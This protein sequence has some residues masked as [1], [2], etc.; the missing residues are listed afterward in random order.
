MTGL[1]GHL[2]FLGAAVLA[3]FVVVRF[4]VRCFIRGVLWRRS[5]FVQ[6]HAVHGPLMAGQALAG[7]EAGRAADGPRPALRRGESL[8]RGS[9][10]LRS[11]GR[12]SAIAVDTRAGGA[13]PGHTEDLAVE[14][15]LFGDLAVCGTGRAVAAVFDE[16]SYQIAFRLPAMERILAVLADRRALASDV[17]RV[18]AAC[19]YEPYADGLERRVFVRLI[20]ETDGGASRWHHVG[21]AWIAFRDPPRRR[22]LFDHGRQTVP[23][24]RMRRCLTL[25][26]NAAGEFVG[27]VAHRGAGVPN[28]QPPR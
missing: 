1:H 28:P 16:P 9:A 6:S 17:C 26:F 10:R 14:G 8:P 2:A 4:A 21:E 15:R 7:D 5:G 11:N 22:G 18:M 12:V 23:K 19:R 27:W 25:Y 24:M 13:G 3:A 20:S